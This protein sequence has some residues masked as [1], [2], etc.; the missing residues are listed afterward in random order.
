MSD[1]PPNGTAVCPDE[2]PAPHLDHCDRNLTTHVIDTLTARHPAP[3]TQRTS[4]T[5]RPIRCRPL[6]YGRAS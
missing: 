1:E 6:L 3:S 4:N 2:M 5:L